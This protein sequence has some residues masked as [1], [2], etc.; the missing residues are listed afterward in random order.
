L[1]KKISDK[2][3]E[4]SLRKINFTL[5]TEGSEEFKIFALRKAEIA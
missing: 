2:L 1:K 5:A 4:K 3:E